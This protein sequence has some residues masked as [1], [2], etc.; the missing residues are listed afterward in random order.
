ML[1]RAETDVILL[2]KFGVCMTIHS[3]SILSVVKYCMLTW[4]RVIH[5]KNLSSTGPFLQV[6]NDTLLVPIR[7]LLPCHSTVSCPESYPQHWFQQQHFWKCERRNYLDICQLTQHNKM[8][9]T[10]PFKTNINRDH[11][12]PNNS[13]ILQASKEASESKEYHIICHIAL[14]VN[15]FTTF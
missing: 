8:P 10:W 4:D 12:A 9:T 1:D 13:E 14:I 5:P 15:V 6:S 7:F 3:P 11:Y 2:C